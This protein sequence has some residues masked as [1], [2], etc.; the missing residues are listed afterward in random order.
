[1]GPIVAI[2]EHAL[3]DGSSCKLRAG[4]TSCLELAFCG[5]LTTVPDASALVAAAAVVAIG[6]R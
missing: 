5:R 2:S 3:G 6:A 1:M 4:T